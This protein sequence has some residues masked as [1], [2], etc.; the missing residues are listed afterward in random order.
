MHGTGNAAYP[1]D[2]LALALARAVQHAAGVGIRDGEAYGGGGGLDREVVS[3]EAAAVGRHERQRERFGRRERGFGDRL[4]RFGELDL[5]FDG[6]RVLDQRLGLGRV[7]RLGRDRFGLGVWRVGGSGDDSRLGGARLARVGLMAEGG[8]RA[9]SAG[10][11]LD[12]SCS[13]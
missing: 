8:A 6:R 1:S 9:R 5:G 13:R 11:M 7:G 2:A 12:F 4:D 3:H 10:V